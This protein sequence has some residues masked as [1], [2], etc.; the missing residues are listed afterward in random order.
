MQTIFN[1]NACYEGKLASGDEY[2]HGKLIDLYKSDRIESGTIQWSVSHYEDKK[3]VF[4]EKLLYL[5][6]GYEERHKV[7]VTALGAV[8]KVV[9]WNRSEVD[10]YIMD[11][12][13]NPIDLLASNGDLEIT[14]D[15]QNILRV[16]LHDHNGLH[17][18]NL[19][20][21]TDDMLR[22]FAPSYLQNGMIITNEVESF[23]Y[24]LKP[25]KAASIEQTYIAA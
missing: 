17:T 21:L 5:I 24:N 22:V 23:Y 4:K 25:I 20:F 3:N 7:S 1:T 13:D 11:I 8:G 6:K 10:G 9:H 16:H 12:T 15:H 19:Y 18:M 14:L 2:Q